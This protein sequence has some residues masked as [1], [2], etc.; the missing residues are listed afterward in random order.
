MLLE[1]MRRTEF[2]IQNRLNRQLF[3][4]HYRVRF[5]VFEYVVVDLVGL[6]KSENQAIIGQTSSQVINC[7]FF[8]H[9]E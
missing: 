1:K 9:S 3:Q 8:L 4:F 2:M 5:V 7:G 6:L